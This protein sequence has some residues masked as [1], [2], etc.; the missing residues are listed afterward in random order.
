[1]SCFQGLLVFP[2]C[3]DA[4]GCCVGTPVLPLT[5]ERYHLG[6]VGSKWE[7]QVLAHLEAEQDEIG[8]PG[9]EPTKV[10]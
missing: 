5:E 9:T 10:R 4:E 7:E 8:I 1:M 3:Y 2:P 6:D